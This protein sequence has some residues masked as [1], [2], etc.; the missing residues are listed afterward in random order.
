MPTLDGIDA[1]SQILALF[2]E[3]RIILLSIYHTPQY[4][5][6]ALS[7]GACGYVLKDAAEDE[8][9][10]AIRAVHSGEHYFSP[11]IGDIAKRYF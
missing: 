6:H 7:A 4:V 10:Q 5:Q 1:T 8:L 3:L 11:K 9:V 2:P